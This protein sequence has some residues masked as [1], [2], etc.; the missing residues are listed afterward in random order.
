MK[1]IR[2]TI[3][4]IMSCYICHGCTDTKDKVTINMLADDVMEHFE[5]TRGWQ[6]VNQIEAVPNKNELIATISDSAEANILNNSLK[7]DYTVPSL[8][9][10]Q[11]FKDVQID[12]EFMVPT[13]SNAGVYVMGRYEI[14]ILD[15]YG[16]E[17]PKFSDL[18]GIYQYWDS[19]KKGSERGSGGVAPMVNAAKAPGEWQTM[20]I[21]FQA[22]RFDSM[23]DKTENAKFISVKVNDILVQ[24]N[25]EVIKSTRQGSERLNNEVAE[26]P[27]LIQGNHGPIA[28]RKYEVTI[29]DNMSK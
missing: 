7:I 1:F 28:I 27:I 13:G 2:I 21:V 23:G 6:L 16:V 11:N 29:L 24:E 25:Q 18:G 20:S 9:T 22:P 14:Q 12:L 3:C 17:K 4:I 5:P 19:T 8:L 26:G 15:S 10:K